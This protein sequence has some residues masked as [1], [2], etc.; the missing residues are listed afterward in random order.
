MVS[1]MKSVLIVDDEPVI[2]KLLSKQLA[3]RYEVT[4]VPNGSQ[5]LGEVM[6]SRPDVI[7]LDINL[8]GLNGVQLL[9]AFHEFA[10]TVPVIV[11]TGFDSQAM[12]KEAME[13]GAYAF[14][15]KPFDLHQLD[16]VLAAA[17][18]EPLKP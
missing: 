18:T 1:P 13:S 10:P 11:T 3:G 5:A 7:V 17:L 12:A 14:V 4:T 15:P 9:R 2:C 8:P 16:K 6:R